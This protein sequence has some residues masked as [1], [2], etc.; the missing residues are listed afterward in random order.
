M[1]IR[2][3]VT[4]MWGYLANAG[5]AD[6]SGTRPEICGEAADMTEVLHLV[7]EAQPDVAVIDIS[8]KT[9]SGL[10][11]IKRIKDSRAQKSAASRA[12]LGVPL[13]RLSRSSSSWLV[14][15]VVAS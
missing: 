8:L 4:L 12:D 9:G 10:D 14:R 15:P 6:R 1:F 2:T 13:F 3:E 7:M 5:L 11:L